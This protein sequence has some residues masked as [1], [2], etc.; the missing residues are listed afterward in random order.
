M[1]ASTSGGGRSDG[2]IE[3]ATIASFFVGGIPA[4][5]RLNTPP[6]FRLEFA[7]ATTTFRIMTGR[8]D[9]R[10]GVTPGVAEGAEEGDR[11]CPAP[12][13][14]ADRRSREKHSQCAR[15]CR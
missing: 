9:P 6:V 11:S 15:E 4:G 7:R 13:S 14:F 8:S 10:P 2:Q 5:T 3:T 12:R 1:P